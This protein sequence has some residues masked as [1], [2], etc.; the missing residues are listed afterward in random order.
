MK[1][2][3]LGII[4]NNVNVSATGLSI[5]ISHEAAD[6]VVQF[7]ADIFAKNLYEIRI[8]KKRMFGDMNDMCE[9]MTDCGF[10]GEFIE[11]AIEKL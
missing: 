11:K 10:D 8:S 3:I 4:E 2:K 5:M 9:F 1:D 7:M 6:E